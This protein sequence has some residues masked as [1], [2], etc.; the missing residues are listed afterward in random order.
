MSLSRAEQNREFKRNIIYGTQL[1][2]KW[3]IDAHELS[4]IVLKQNLSI[5]DLPR[6]FN[7]YSK[8]DPNY[9]RIDPEKLTEIIKYNSRSLH[10]KAFWIPEIQK[11]TDYVNVLPKR[12][13]K[14]SVHPHGIIRYSKAIPDDFQPSKEDKR[15]TLIKRDKRETHIKQTQREPENAIKNIIEGHER[16]IKI[17]PNVFSL[18]GKVWFV[19][20]KNK[21]W[22]LYPDYEK[23]KYIVHLLELTK[24]FSE[25]HEYYIYNSDLI[26]KIKGV[27]ASSENYDAALK[28]DLN[29]SD[30]GK[31]LTSEDFKKF[32]DI[33]YDLLEELNVAKQADDPIKE[34][35]AKENF[36][37]YQAYI[38]NDYG[39]KSQVSK[40]GLKIYFGIYYRSSRESEKLRQLIKNQINNAI[41]DFKKGM[42]TLTK[43]LQSCLKTKLN[44]TVYAPE[45]IHW[46][47]SL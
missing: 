40:N 38:L 21:E 31:E 11:A 37:K 4:Y 6:R 35:E 13:H 26:S 46:Q 22:G 17:N 33:G 19:K 1:T 23:Y 32:K 28:E 12:T 20:F 2:K 34:K 43:H 3:G 16:D 36:K 27:S 29:E 44:K 7:R 5:L 39:I 14:T 18:I 10:D 24:P 9:Y 45:R 15:E 30:L 25:N 42:P 41:K 8:Y 47:V